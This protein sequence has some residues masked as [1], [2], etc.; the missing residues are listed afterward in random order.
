MLRLFATCLSSCFSARFLQGDH[1]WWLFC[2]QC[3]KKA[4]QC[5][6]L[7]LAES[8]FFAALKSHYVK[9]FERKESCPDSRLQGVTIRSYKKRFAQKVFFRIWSV[10]R[11]F[12]RAPKMHVYKVKWSFFQC[13][14]WGIRSQNFQKG[15]Y[16]AYVT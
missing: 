15:G 4:H 14:T 9:Y 1:S 3:E 16:I 7:F 2:Q 11:S 12:F 10:I 6:A 8:A 5:P 13:F